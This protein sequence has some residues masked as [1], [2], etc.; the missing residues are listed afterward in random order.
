MTGDDRD[1]DVGA[2]AQQECVRVIVRV[3]PTNERELKAQAETSDVVSIAAKHGSDVPNHVHVGSA[4]WDVDV[5]YTYDAVFGAATTQEEIYG[6][7]ESS[8]EQVVQ[9]FNCT[10]FAYGQTGTGK[11]H[12]MMG[13]DAVLRDGDTLPV[14][15]GIIPRAV[16]GL[17]RELRAVSTSGAGAVV[18]CSYMQIYNN[19]VFD[20]LQTTRAQDQKPLQVREMIKGNAKH[21]YVSG[22]SEFRVASAQ[23]VLEL[24]KVGAQNRTIRATECNEKSS[25]SHAL[26]QVNIEVESRGTESTTIIRRAKLNLVDLAGSEKW[27]T[28]I[29]MSNDRT[30]E[31]RNINASLSALGNVIAALTDKKRSHIPYRDSKLTRLLQDSLGG[32]T[33]TIVIATISPSEAAIE[34]T[35]STLQ[36]AERAKQISLNIQV[37]E[38]V[39]DAVLLA[40]AQKEIRRLQQL[41]QAS[42]DKEQLATLESRVTSLEEELRQVKAENLQLKR[43]IKAKREEPRATAQPAS[44]PSN[45][46]AEP[47]VAQAMAPP[48]PTNNAT[49]DDANELQTYDLQEQYQL[50]QLHRLQSER[51][52]L[53]AQLEA[54]HGPQPNLPED[55]DVCPMCRRVI[56]HHTDEELDRCIELEAQAMAPAQSPPELPRPKTSGA[57]SALPALRRPSSKASLTQRK[58]VVSPYLDTS[59]SILGS[60]DSCKP[61]STPPT[62][63]NARPVKPKPKHSIVKQ[64]KARQKAKDRLAASPYVE[65]SAIKKPEA[66]VESNQSKAKGV[67]CNDV[68]DIGLNLT[69]YS[70]RYDSW[71]PC[72][73]VGY[74]SKRKMH[75]CHYDYGDKQWLVLADKKIDVLG[76]ASD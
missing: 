14:D 67:L 10:I 50:S 35:L 28:D 56:D 42:P 9:G 60:R 73:V 58:D 33:R 32:N 40:R 70:Y 43:R 69:V 63:T 64:M 25:R 74:D 53:E 66:S 27:D 31:L 6:Y 26:L 29:A 61:P 18:H 48:T 68:R 49:V 22:I 12:T 38:V 8:V 39:D 17:F 20:L 65:V 76:R 15:S 41:L 51:R 23:D 52:Q 75:C 19:Q 59:C 2:V 36:F 45:Q 30:R 46:V 71:Y 11:T 13:P 44:S 37:N 34:E 62:P 4:S 3:R 55:D 24:L 21:I 57:A 54:M 72:T 5:G 16:S 1:E 7:L 47:S